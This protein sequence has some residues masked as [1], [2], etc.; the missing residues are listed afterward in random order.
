MH[1]TEHAH[2]HTHA[3]TQIHMHAGTPPDRQTLIFAGSEPD[4]GRSLSSLN[5]QKESELFLL[6]DFPPPEPPSEPLPPKPPLCKQNNTNFSRF[7]LK[8]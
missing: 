6:I 3:R 7:I 8:C 2:A 1:F 4:D 5:I